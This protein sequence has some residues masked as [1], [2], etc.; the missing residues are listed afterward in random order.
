MT[1]YPK[2]LLL[3]VYFNCSI[4]E[5][6]KFSNF[7]YALDVNRV[8]LVDRVHEDVKYSSMSGMTPFHL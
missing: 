6:E 5:L 3:F 8:G 7:L 1:L 2:A 4:D